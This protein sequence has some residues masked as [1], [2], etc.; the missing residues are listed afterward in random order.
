[1]QKS[2]LQFFSS[3]RVVSLFIF[4]LFMVFTSNDSFALSSATQQ[5]TS[6]LFVEIAKKQNP[7]VVNVSVKSKTEK[8]NN[9]FRSPRR[10]PRPGPG[11]GR[12]Q[13][14]FRDFYDK[15]FGERPNNQKP[16]RGMGSGFIIDKE[17]HALT[18]Y[19]VIEGAD[20]IVV[21]LEDALTKLLECTAGA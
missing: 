19:H 6:N 10:R 18:N 2:F 7:A 15:F 17:G 3:V 5:L 13:D 4:S 12:P 8:S 9:N 20:E 14:P 11:Q 16:K 1:M 21:L